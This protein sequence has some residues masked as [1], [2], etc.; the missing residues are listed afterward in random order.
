MPAACPH[1]AAEITALP[2]FVP[3]ATLEE[4]I[5]GAKDALIKENALLKGRIGE[6]EPLAE[7]GTKA[8]KELEQVKTRGARTAALQAAGLSVDLLEHLEMLHASASAGSEDPVEFDAWL[9]AD[10]GARA[11]PLL[12]PHFSAPPAA[13]PPAAAAKPPAAKLPA[14]TGRAPSV[15][16]QKLTP[17]DVQAELAKFDLRDPKQREQRAAR[18]AELQAQVIAQGGA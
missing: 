18:M 16:H 6:L 15:G 5:K 7:A 14:D 9:Q 3:Q 2:G 13:S 10:D 8:V 17:A 12:R 11:H 4:R 1:C